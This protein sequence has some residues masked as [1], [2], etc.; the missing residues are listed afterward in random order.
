MSDGICSLGSGAFPL[1]MISD[2]LIQ[3]V[4]VVSAPLYQNNN[5]F[6]YFPFRD[7]HSLFF[8]PHFVVLNKVPL[9]YKY[10]P[11]AYVFHVGNYPRVKLVDERKLMSN[12]RENKTTFFKVFMAFAV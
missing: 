9:A 2:S 10:F 7:S 4:S 1:R 3:I 11:S 12:S 5:W 8:G 6:I